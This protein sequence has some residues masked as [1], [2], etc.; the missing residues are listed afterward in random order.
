MTQAYS[1]PAREHEPYALPDIEVF[2]LSASAQAE[3]AIESRSETAFDVCAEYGQIFD[4]V[5]AMKWFHDAVTLEFQDGWYWHSCFPGCM[6][7]GEPMGP[8]ATEPEALADA[9]SD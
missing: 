7:D 3:S 5:A 4:N 8:F 2:W 6:P 1:D 9:Q